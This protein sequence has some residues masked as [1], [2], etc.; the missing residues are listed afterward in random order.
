[1]ASNSKTSF[2]GAGTGAGSALICL[3]E[4]VG[5][6]PQFKWAR[7]WERRG[8]GDE[9][10]AVGI[11]GV[12]RLWVAED[13][14]DP[15]AGQKSDGPLARTRRSRRGERM[16]GTGSDAAVPTCGADTRAYNRS[17]VPMRPHSR[18]HAFWRRYPHVPLHV[19]ALRRCC[20]PTAAR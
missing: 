20:V 16:T 6:L 1:M 15:E 3:R 17:S 4:F 2:G 19:D 9:A 5:H 18:R 8:D 7:L 10:T 13:G 11:G 14:S 12:R